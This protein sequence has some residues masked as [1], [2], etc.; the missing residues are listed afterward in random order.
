MTMKKTIVITG[1]SSGIGA[2]LAAQLGR[3][4]HRLAMAAR[5]EAELNAVG[6]SPPLPPDTPSQT[7]E[8]AAAAIVKVI[9]QPVAEIYTNPALAAM[10]LKYFQDV[11]AFERDA[12]AR[13]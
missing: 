5:R 10:A 12:A 6:G 13:R 11:D 2:A 3:Q 1:A 9:E 8:E 7:P 4:G